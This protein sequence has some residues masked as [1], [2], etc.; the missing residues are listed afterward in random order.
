MLAFDQSQ[1]DAFAQA[2][3]ETFVSNTVGHLVQRFP[4]ETAQLDRDELASLVR[5]A[6]EDG[7]TWG[8]TSAYDVR[9]FAECLVIY[10]TDFAKTSTTTWARHILRRDD[11]SGREKMTTI[12]TYQ[13]FNREALS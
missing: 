12:A 13:A 4:K 2:H 1:T 8:I 3:F 11:L 9:R 6:V 5:H 7:R 10:G